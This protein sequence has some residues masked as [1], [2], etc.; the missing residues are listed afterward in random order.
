M[1]IRGAAEATLRFTFD[2]VALRGI[3]LCMETG[4]WNENPD[5]L[6]VI[7]S[8]PE[9]ATEHLPLPPSDDE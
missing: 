1:R 3:A 7:A 8:P 2:G 5:D 4:N 9:W 6:H